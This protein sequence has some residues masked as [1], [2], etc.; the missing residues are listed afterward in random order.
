MYLSGDSLSF[1]YRYVAGGIFLAHS[2][3][4]PLRSL[5]FE[6]DESKQDDWIAEQLVEKCHGAFTPVGRRVCVRIS[7]KMSPTKVWV[8]V[9]VS[10]CV[11]RVVCLSAVRVCICMYTL[12]C[13]CVC[14]R[15]VRV[16]VRAG[17]CRPP[18]H[19][20]VRNACAP[21]CLCVC[22]FVVVHICLIFRMCPVVIL[23]PARLRIGLDLELHI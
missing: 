17:Q 2:P 4:L 19:A 16:R 12:V 11:M 9:C 14:L 1:L 15:F 8:C 21:V 10:L 18:K 3:W 7:Y 6:I 13:A 23:A 20:R 22:V 5:K